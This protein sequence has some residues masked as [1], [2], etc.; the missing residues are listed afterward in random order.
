MFAGASCPESSLALGRPCGLGTVA[1]STPIRFGFS[2]AAPRA[3][4]FL[5]VSVSEGRRGGDGRGEEEREREGQLRECTLDSTAHV[6]PEHATGAARP[7]P[8]VES[9]RCTPTLLAAG[10][11]PLYVRRHHDT[12]V[13]SGTR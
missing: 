1:S 12:A 5:L 2:R 6:K 11:R 3:A 10:R 4:S 13:H 9:P 8:S 7:W